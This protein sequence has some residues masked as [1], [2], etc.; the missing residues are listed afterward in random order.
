MNFNNTDFNKIPS[1]ASG[2]LI[3]DNVKIQMMKEEA[4]NERYEELASLLKHIQKTAKEQI[5]Y[6]KSEAESAKKEAKKSNRISV[7]SAIATVITLL[8]SIAA[9]IV[10]LISAGLI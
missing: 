6:A 1:I 10:P 8:V 4:E 5:E 2:S 7:I 3:P 9:L